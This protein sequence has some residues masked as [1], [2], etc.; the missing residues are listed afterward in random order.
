M[1]KQTNNPNTIEIN[2]RPLTHY[3][4]SVTS[5]PPNTEGFTKHLRELETYPVSVDEDGRDSLTLS[6]GEKVISCVPAVPGSM[7]VFAF[8]TASSGQRVRSRLGVE[9]PGADNTDWV[10]CARKLVNEHLLNRE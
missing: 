10:T 9:V 7:E 2:R 5:R 6:D 1:N 4:V 3:I 8:W